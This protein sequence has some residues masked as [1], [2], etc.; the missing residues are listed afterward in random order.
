MYKIKFASIAYKELEHI[1][2]FDKK[3]YTRLINAIS[4]L[5]KNP[6]L[7]KALKA[8]LKGDYSLRIADYRVI[9]TIHKNVLIIYIIDVGHRKNI[10]R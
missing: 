1:Y 2:Q 10:Y 8:R 3:L 7:G 5:Q 4:A 6:Y 9:Y